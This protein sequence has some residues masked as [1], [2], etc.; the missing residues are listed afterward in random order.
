MDP[1]RHTDFMGMGENLGISYILGVIV[2]T[3]IPGGSLATYAKVMTTDTDPDTW[4]ALPKK[5]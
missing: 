1:E 2:F 3:K 5:I 4:L